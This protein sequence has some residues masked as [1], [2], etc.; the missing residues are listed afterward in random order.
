VGH[1]SVLRQHPRE[2]GREAE[3]ERGTRNLRMHKAT[4]PAKVVVREGNGRKSFDLLLSVGF[5]GI[6][7]RRGISYFYD[8]QRQR[9][10]ILYANSLLRIPV[11]PMAKP[12]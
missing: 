12:T 10:I 4:L 6:N 1:V 8:T 2:C 11:R 3:N 9:I 5:G 7:L